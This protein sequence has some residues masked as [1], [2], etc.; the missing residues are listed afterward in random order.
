M[1]RH[2][3]GHSSRVNGL[4]AG[5]LGIA[6]VLGVAA[7]GWA[8][9]RPGERPTASVGP[10]GSTRSAPPSDPAVRP[11]GAASALA[12]PAPDPTSTPTEV[13]RAARARAGLTEDDLTAGVLSR[14]FPQRGTG[15]LAVVPG[16]ARAPRSGRLV[17]VRVEIEGGLTID[18]R[19]FADF[20]L[21][22]LNDPRSWAHDGYTFARTDGAADVRLVL[23]SP[24][25]SARL[26]LPLRTFG[27]MSCHAGDATVLTVSRWVEAIPGYGTDSTGYRRYLVN[28]EV[29][30]AL[31][32]GHESCPGTGRRAPVMMQ[33]TKGLQGCRP[34][35]WPYPGAG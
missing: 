33:Q 5:V 24:D 32:H 16:S 6:L 29:G 14:S 30:H 18:A 35:S 26:C 31:G 27:R 23:A 10:V 25:T 8:L 7:G 34:N 12:T 19:R 9:V 15:R 2:E 4:A 21:V 17:R 13:T 20:A 3:T 22:T 28:H 11:S 1:P